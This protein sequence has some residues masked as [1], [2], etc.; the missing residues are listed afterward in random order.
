[1]NRLVEL[2]K[3]TN[4]GHKLLSD[5]DFKEYAAL[6]KAEFQGRKAELLESGYIN[7]QVQNDESGDIVGWTWEEPIIPEPI[8]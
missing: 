8:P 3:R 6:R 2:Y 7:I 4:G 1:M 5:A